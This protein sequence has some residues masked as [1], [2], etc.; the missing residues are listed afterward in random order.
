MHK[1]NITF[2]DSIYIRLRTGL[3]CGALFITALLFHPL[4]YI[5]L[6]CLVGM[7][8]L[9]EWNKMQLG[10]KKNRPSLFLFGA[11]TTILVLLQFKLTYSIL[12]PSFILGLNLLSAVWII[13]LAFDLMTKGFNLSHRFPTLVS[14]LYIGT[15]IGSL[16]ALPHIIADGPR[17]VL[18]LMIIV[19]SADT[20]AYLTGKKFGRHKLIPHVSPNK[21]KEGYL[22]GLVFAL[23]CAGLIFFFSR[24][25]TLWF[26]L[27]LG[28]IVS[29]FGLIGDL[30]ES[31]FKRTAQVKDSS[32][33][34]PGHGGF[35]D[36]FDALYGFFPFVF[37]YLYLYKIITFS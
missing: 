28:V 19:W 31:K 3:I 15:A 21:T 7:V 8:S 29:F 27:G 22:G 36:R 13:L 24:I 16:I 6:W 32:Q 26:W 1:I 30:I 4:S 14:F 12:E 34:L 5:F 35:L 10:R 20:G 18:Y 33:L 11:L 25:E 23:F 37:I 17:V 2:L 9:W